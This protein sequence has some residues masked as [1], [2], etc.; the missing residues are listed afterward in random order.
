MIYASFSPMQ[1][2]AEDVCSN[3]TFENVHVKDED[4][5]EFQTQEVITDGEAAD[6]KMEQH[7]IIETQVL[8][9]SKVQFI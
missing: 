9:G 5:E 7:L 6:V 2:T 3:Q 4:V 1:A 8:L